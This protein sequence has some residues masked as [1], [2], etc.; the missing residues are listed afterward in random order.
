MLRKDG[1]LNVSSF[2]RLLMTFAVVGALGIVSQVDAA[3][4]G[5]DRKADALPSDPA[6]LATIKT[7]IALARKGELAQASDVKESMSDPIARNVVEWAILRSKEV[8]FQRYVAFISD[9]PGWPNIGLLRRRVEAALWKERLDPQ[10]V[11]GYFGKDQPVCTKNQ[12][13]Q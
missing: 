10:I 9:N 6:T 11:R 13:L 4:A 8:E 5:P 1:G 3:G 2:S 12:I 7:A